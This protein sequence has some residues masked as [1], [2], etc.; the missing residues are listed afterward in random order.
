[1]EF[2]WFVEQVQ[3]TWRDTG[4]EPDVGLELPQWLVELGFELRQLRPLVEAPRPADEVWQWPN[5]FV[6]VGLQR[7][8]DT[9]R[10]DPERAAR[11]PAVPVRA[12]RVPAPAH[13]ARGDRGQA[14]AR[15]PAAAAGRCGL[16]RTRRTHHWEPSAP[17]APP[18]PRSRPLPACDRRCPSASSPPAGS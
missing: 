15:R 2:A 8:V 6:E 7:M 13:R 1:P 10:V 5:A 16:A 12:G 4:G 14:L 17:D 18:V 9:G 3:A 11:L